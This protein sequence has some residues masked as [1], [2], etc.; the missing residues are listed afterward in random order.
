VVPISRLANDKTRGARFDKDA[1]PPHTQI[2]A[3]NK[4]AV[5][6]HLFGWWNVALRDITL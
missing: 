5:F 6:L 1:A 4:L 2:A 3:T